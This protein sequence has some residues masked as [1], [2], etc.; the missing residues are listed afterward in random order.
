MRGAIM[1]IAIGLVGL[2][3]ACAGGGLGWLRFAKPE[4]RPASNEKIEATPARLAR[5]EY[6]AEH[7]MQ[8]FHCHSEHDPKRAGMPIVNGKGAGG[9]V[10]DRTLGLPGEVQ[11]PN[12]T[13]A[14]LGNVTDGELMRAM[15]EGIGHDGRVLFPM[16]PYRDYR[17]MSDEDLRAIIVYLR[18]LPAAPKQTQKTVIDFPVNYFIRGVPAPVEGVVTAPN[19]NDSVAY[20]KYLVNLA[21][22]HGCHT[23]IDKRGQGIE[24]RDFAGG[25]EFALTWRSGKLGP[26]IV[27]ANI[28]TSPDGYFGHATK[29]EFID[30]VKSYA[31]LVDDHPPVDMDV[32]TLMPWREFSGLTEQDLGAIYDYMKTVKPVPGKINPYPDAK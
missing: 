14:A 27:T 18:T 8:C 13:P 23:P 32:N 29:R 15:R 17:S 25:R 30:R 10:F 11:P 4:M 16:M 22:C 12:I 24:G 19:P 28:T 2:S 20:G 9:F 3:A 1:K 26:R 21:S 7:L 5:G 6:L 31:P